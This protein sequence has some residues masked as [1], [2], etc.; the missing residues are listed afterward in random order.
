MPKCR[1]TGISIEENQLFFYSLEK[2]KLGTPVE[3]R[4]SM[5]LDKATRDQLI[6]ELKQIKF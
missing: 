3:V 6:Q 5:I 2:G 4:R 1:Q